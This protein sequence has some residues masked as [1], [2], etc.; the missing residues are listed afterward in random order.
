MRLNGQ[1]SNFPVPIA[2]YS[3]WERLILC[4][5]CLR[6]YLT[7][8][9]LP[10]N[11]HFHYVYPFGVGE[12]IPVILYLYPLFF[13]G[14]CYFIGIML[15][16]SPHKWFFLFCISFF[17]VHIGLVLQLIPMTRNA[18]MADR[19]MYIPLLPLLMIVVH[20]AVNYWKGPVKNKIAIP[21]LALYIIILTW[22]AHHLTENWLDLNLIPHDKQ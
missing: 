11:L 14:F 21:L 15:K 3:I 12:H 22:Y 5:Y 2:K 18:I 1:G 4:F 10:V 9:L 17:L 19:Y 13:F 16:R 7:G 6:F 8:L 20:V